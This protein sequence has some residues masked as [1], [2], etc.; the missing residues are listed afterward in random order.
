MYKKIFTSGMLFVAVTAPC[1]ASTFSEQV[2]WLAGDNAGQPAGTCIYNIPD[3]NKPLSQPKTLVIDDNLQNNSVIYTWG[4]FLDFSATCTGSGIS[5]S[6]PK[7]SVPSSSKTFLSYSVSFSGTTSTAPN[8]IYTNNSGLSLK[9]TYLFNQAAPEPCQGCQPFPDSG[10]ASFGTLLAAI[11][12]NNKYVPDNGFESEREKYQDFITMYFFVVKPLSDGRYSFASTTPITQSYQV[13]AELI[14]DGP[15]DYDATPLALRSGYSSI[16]VYAGNV[17]S[18]YA[19]DIGSG[20]V[21]IVRPTCQL[22]TKDYIVPMSNWV[23]IDPVVKPGIFPAYGSQ[24]PVN[25]VM[26]C[27]GKVD[28]TQIS[29]EDANSVSSRQDV[30]LYDSTGGTIID[31]LAIQLLYNNA[32][33]PTDNTKIVISGLGTTKA[34]ADSTPLFDSTSIVNFTARY[35]QT[36]A[37]KM[38]GTEYTGPVTGKL[39]IWVTYN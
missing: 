26:E 13:K 39:N 5:N 34:I 37:I 19:F 17:Y 29:F 36:D 12:I 9:Y 10:D 4:N 3:N 20:G 7:I 23:S 30:S 16:Q 22:K 32:A 31:G 6:D 15:I 2:T 21:Q 11:R 14:K 1:H 35:V 24:V 18:T 38:N 33:I 28:D 8:N 27:S 25:I